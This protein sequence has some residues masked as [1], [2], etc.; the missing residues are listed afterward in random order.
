MTVYA[1]PDRV[2]TIIFDIDSTLYTNSAYAF[3][4]ID[5]QLRRYAAVADISADEARAQIAAYREKWAAEHDGQKISL[6]NALTAFGIPIAESI[7]WRR[8]LL[9]PALFLQP[10]EE[11]RRTLERLAETYVLICVTNNPV[12]PARKTLEAL[13]VSDLFP[14]IIGLDTC[15]VSKPD[16]RPFEL[17]ARLSG[18]AVSHCLSVGDR[19]DIDIALPLSMGMGAV[20]VS[21]VADVYRLPYVLKNGTR[22]E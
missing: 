8:E 5:I 7:R 19:Y 12:L 9:E 13:G 11:L 10:D 15:G 18:A 14:E 16:R 6:G 2:H 1:L 20:L 4:Q 3:E 21:G 17:A 22:P